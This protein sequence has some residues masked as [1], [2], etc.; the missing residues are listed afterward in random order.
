MNWNPL[1]TRGSHNVVPPPH[2]MKNYGPRPNSVSTTANWKVDLYLDFLTFDEVHERSHGITKRNWGIAFSRWWSPTPPSSHN[3]LS[4]QRDP[5]PTMTKPC[6]SRTLQ[7]P[8]TKQNKKIIESIAKF[9]T[10]GFCLISS[11]Y[12]ISSRQWLLFWQPGTTKT[13]GG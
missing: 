8:K 9:S 10:T 6:H 11:L 5:I 7:C 12:G 4:L 1:F 3:G 2:A 13:R